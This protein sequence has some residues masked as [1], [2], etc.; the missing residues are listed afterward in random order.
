MNTA[1]QFT[2]AWCAQQ[3]SH[4]LQDAQ[5]GESSTG[6]SE[7]EPL[8]PVL[9]D[10]A[11]TLS[12]MSLQPGINCVIGDGLATVPVG[13]MVQGVQVRPMRCVLGNSYWQVLEHHSLLPVVTAACV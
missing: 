9:Q 12:A 13:L 2:P 1:Q 6:G 8:H 4:S 7:P 5:Q 3:G 10:V 11:A